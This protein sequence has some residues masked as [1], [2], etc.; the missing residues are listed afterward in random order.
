MKFNLSQKIRWKFDANYIHSEVFCGLNQKPN[1]IFSNY[2]SV[3]HRLFCLLE[4]NR[5]QSIR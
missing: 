5:N 4:V 1:G 3:E 2:Q